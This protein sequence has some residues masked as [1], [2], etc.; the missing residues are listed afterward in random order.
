M[1]I[2]IRGEGE[3]FEVVGQFEKGKFE[4]PQESSYSAGQDA[5]GRALVKRNAQWVTQLKDE[6]SGNTDAL[7]EWI[8]QGEPE[9]L[10][11]L[12]INMQSQPLGVLLFLSWAPSPRPTRPC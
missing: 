3:S 9:T 1:G 11:T 12:P 2:L 10:F 6:F 4:K 8:L 5:L 7:T